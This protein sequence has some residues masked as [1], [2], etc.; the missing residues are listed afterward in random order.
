[1]IRK[2]K[3]TDA[4]AIALIYNHYI[5][6]STTTFEEK[7]VNEQLILERLNKSKKLPW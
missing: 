7:E 4:L 1:M 6:Y 5:V 2:V 3:E